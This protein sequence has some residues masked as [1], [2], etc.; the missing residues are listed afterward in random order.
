MRKAHGGDVRWMPRPVFFVDE[1][2]RRSFWHHL[3]C[4]TRHTSTWRGFSH[5]VAATMRN[6]GTSLR[7]VV[8]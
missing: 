1:I 3:R 2:A 6:R 4:T 5:D 7:V 8:T